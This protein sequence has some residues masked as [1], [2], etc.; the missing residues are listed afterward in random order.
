M[1]EGLAQTAILLLAYLAAVSFGGYLLGRAAE[2]LL[3]R[4]HARLVGGVLLGFIVTFPEYLFAVVS[5]VAGHNDVALGSAFGGNILLFTV[6]FGL[7]LFF[8]SSGGR[9]LKY[10]GLGFDLAVLVASTL[11]I[12]LGALF[13]ILDMPIGLILIV[14]YV[15]YIVHSARK[16]I[17]Q[18]REEKL[19]SLKAKASSALLFIVGLILIALTIHPLLDEV[20][21]FSLLVGI[22][23]IVTSFTLVP[24]GDELPEMVAMLTLFTS[25]SGGK[26]GGEGGRAAYANL[27]GSKVQSNTLLIGTIVVAASLL[28]NPITVSDRYTFYTLYAMVATTFMGVG[29][30]LGRPSRTVGATLIAS[31][32]A[33][34]LLAFFL[35]V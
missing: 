16:N 2:L 1:A 27:I 6:P 32:L 15:A 10:E 12:L 22:P 23:P 20:V 14:L 18:E 9:E 5:T 17:P 11:L 8:G 30:A 29:A 13:R 28:E 31:Y 4:V 35:V 3:G 25:K 7:L 24:V 21:D 33:L 19:L 26:S 34:M